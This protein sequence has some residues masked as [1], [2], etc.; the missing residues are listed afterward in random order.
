MFTLVFGC[1]SPMDHSLSDDATCDAVREALEGLLS[2]C[3]YANYPSDR[4][5]K[6][7]SSKLRPSG[8]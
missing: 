5:G 7:Y 2:N 4:R 3:F 1:I 8:K 6:S